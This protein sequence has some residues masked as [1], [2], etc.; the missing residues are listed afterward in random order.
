MKRFVVVAIIAAAAGTYGLFGQFN[1]YRRVGRWA[2]RGVSWAQSYRLGLADSFDQELDRNDRF[3]AGGQYSVRGYPTESLGPVEELG[4]EAFPLG[5]KSLLVI[6]QELR[7]ELLGPV[8]GVAFFD[9]GNVWEDT[10]GFDSDL[11]KSLG[12]GLRAITPVGL[13]RLDWAFP[14]DR[15]DGDPSSKLYFGFGNTF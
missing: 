15:R 2:G 13:L 3:F 5:G 6:N 11:F 8:A 1:L 12:V 10:Y 7:F 4:D 9:L 14:L